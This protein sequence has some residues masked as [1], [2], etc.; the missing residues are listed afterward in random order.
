MLNYDDLTQS[1]TNEIMRAALQQQLAAQQARQVEIAK[2]KQAE[3]DRAAQEEA[4]RMKMIEKAEAESFELRKVRAESVARLEH[5]ADWRNRSL[6]A[7]PNHLRPLAA[8]WIKSVPPLADL[9]LYIHKAPVELQR[10]LQ[11]YATQLR[12]EKER[13][14]REAKWEAER[15]ERDEKWALEKR[16]SD[17]RWT[18]TMKALDEK[19]EADKRQR[20]AENEKWWKEE[21]EPKLVASL[22]ELFK[23]VEK[24]L[25]AGKSEADILAEFK[26]GFSRAEEGA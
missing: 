21:G 15:K 25:A 24:D 3:A 6:A 10:E 26:A 20:A 5:A 17:A 9:K 2:Q 1:A 23:E 18:A 14:E 4:E 11:R 13:K 7:F 22:G 19:Y 12:L 16:M 8:E